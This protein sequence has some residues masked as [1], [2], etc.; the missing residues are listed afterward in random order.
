[1]AKLKKS[2][3]NLWYRIGINGEYHHVGND[4]D[5]MIDVLH[6][7]RLGTAA[8]IARM[9]AGICS[10]FY[11]GADYI[12]LY[13]GGKTIDLLEK[14]S[15]DEIAYIKRELARREAVKTV[16][17]GYG[18]IVVTLDADRPGGG[19]IRSDLHEEENAEAEGGS[20][21]DTAHERYEVG[22]DAIESMILAHAI[23]GIDVQDLKYVDGVKTACEALGNNC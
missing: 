10:D 14:I 18:G 22:I 8:S 16:H 21:E 11:G 6:E 3:M 4:I 9:D 2:Q 12:S 5:A 19:A 15:D 20:E 7:A 1:M 23:V 17:V 13:W